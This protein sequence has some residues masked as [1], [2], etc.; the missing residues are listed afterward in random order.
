M[1]WREVSVADQRRDFVA[2]AS[3]DGANVSALCA[4]FGISRQT[5]HVWLRRQA[6]GEFS[7]ED[8]SRR[9]HTSPKRIEGALA[10]QIVAVRREHPAWGARKI[11]AVLARSGVAPPAVSTVHAVLTRAG[12]VGP[13]RPAQGPFGSFEHERPNALWQMDFKGREQIRCGSWVHPLT[14]IDDHSRFAVGLVACANQ[15]TETVKSALTDAF[16]HHGL[17]DAFYVDNGS[18]WGGGVPGQWT[19]LRVWLLKMGIELIH[20]TPYR[21]QGRGKNERFHRTLGAEVFALKPLDG[22]GQVERAFAHWRHVYNYERP[23]EA[24]GMQPPASRYRASPRGFPED[25]P[26]PEYDEGEIIRKAGANFTVSF[27]NRNWHVP[28]AFT[29]E[30]LAIRPRLPDGDFSICFGATEIARISLKETQIAEP[31]A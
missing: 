8:R 12:L 25:L 22:L 21:P 5:G 24:L 28:K 15:R 13:A 1:G 19:P 4:R 11:A 30:R 26:A 3:L 27:K 2:L 10:A 17:P 6:E 29:G 16:R 7:F 20:A 18:P 31:E 23:H 14:V 9:P